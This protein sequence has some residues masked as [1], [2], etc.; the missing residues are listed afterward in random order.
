[1]TVVR[2]QENTTPLTWLAGDYAANL[3]TAGT[4]AAVFTQ[5]SSYYAADT[6]TANAMVVTLSPAPP[7]LSALI[8]VPL[9]ITKSAAANTGA[10]TLA[11]N[12]LAAEAVITS[13]GAALV[14]DQWPAGAVG[15]VIF[16][17]AAFS[18]LTVTNP[19]QTGSNANGTWFWNDAGFLEQFGSHTLLANN[20]PQNFS[21]P[22]PFPSGNP[23]LAFSTSAMSTT[24]PTN[25]A[26][27]PTLNATTFSLTSY[28]ASD[29]FWRAIG[30]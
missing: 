9:Y 10:V 1:M 8:G 21:F 28:E 17:G 26:L 2:N 14:N 7:N 12:G 25:H 20:T 3:L 24:N 5:S 19:G 4:L 22:I 30:Q 29:V 27:G 16:N 23:P 15:L 11:A 18:L 13:D 6:G